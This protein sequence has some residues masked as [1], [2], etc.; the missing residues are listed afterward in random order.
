MK[1]KKIIQK[2]IKVTPNFVFC[3][4]KL[5]FDFNK[6]WS[7]RLF[8]R[9]FYEYAKRGTSNQVIS[10]IPRG[11][12]NPI[13]IRRGGTDIVC[14]EQIFNQEEYSFLLDLKKEPNTILDCGGYIG[15]SAAY[16]SSKFKKAKIFVI[17]PDSENYIFALLNNR[18]NKNVR[19]LNSAVWSENT[20]LKESSRPEGAMTIQFSE[21]KDKEKSD[22]NV[23]AYTISELL[24]IA[25]F[26]NIDFLKVDIEGAEK[27]LFSSK[28]CKKW[29][30]NCLII[31]CELHDDINSKTYTKGCREA[32]ENAL[33]YGNF[34]KKIS[35]QYNY[36]INQNH[37][38]Y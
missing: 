21:V 18:Y 36:Y 34:I 5:G 32:L 22:E 24:K 35:G 19:I 27:E 3:F 29:I 31:S 4:G 2:L 10:I 37:P 33:R 13:F 25:N 12:K 26:E 1:I 11:F 16:F 6:P 23:K 28:D 9:Y 17:E 7:N 15:L 38:N 30:N 14:F 8:W 20:L